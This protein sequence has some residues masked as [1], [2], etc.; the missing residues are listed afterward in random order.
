MGDNICAVCMR[1]IS[2]HTIEEVADCTDKYRMIEL[3][4]LANKECCS[5]GE[6]ADLQDPNGEY[7]CHGCLSW[8]TQRNDE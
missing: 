1:R 5:C 6:S 7:W 2:H 3:E 8:Q 4:R